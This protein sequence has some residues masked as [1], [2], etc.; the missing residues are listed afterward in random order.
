VS[1]C[2][3]D[4]WFFSVVSI[5]ASVLYLPPGRDCLYPVMQTS[6]RD[7]NDPGRALLAEVAL[8]AELECRLLRVFEHHREEPRNVESY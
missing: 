4:S 3:F 2:N 1:Y 6:H 5:S 7:E 8:A